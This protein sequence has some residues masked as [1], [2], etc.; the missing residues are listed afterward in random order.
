VWLNLTTGFISIACARHLD[1]PGQPIDEATLMLRARRR[2][3]LEELQ[4]RHP[5]LIGGIV[6]QESK[7]A[8]YPFRL[9]APKSTVS[10][11]VAREVQSITYGNFKNEAGNV[12]GHSSPYLRALHDVW[13]VMRTLDPRQP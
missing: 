7:T 6:V 3:H 12:H 8:D 13:S 2:E 10:A 9:I 11:L 1:R 5:D 4:G